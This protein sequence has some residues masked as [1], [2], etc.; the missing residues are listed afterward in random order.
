MSKPPCPPMES[1][2]RLPL[3]LLLLQPLLRPH[4]RSPLLQPVALPLQQLVVLP[5]KMPLRS[6]RKRRQINQLLPQKNPSLR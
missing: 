2:P 4:R 5:L 6:R 1:P 3:P